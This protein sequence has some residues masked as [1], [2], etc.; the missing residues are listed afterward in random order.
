VRDVPGWI[1]D[2]QFHHSGLPIQR[3]IQYEGN[4]SPYH[5]RRRRRGPPEQNIK[6]VTRYSTVSAAVVM[7]QGAERPGKAR[8]ELMA[9]PAN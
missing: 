5:A 3:L 6:V 8:A 1:S 2:D 4:P 7:I 9:A